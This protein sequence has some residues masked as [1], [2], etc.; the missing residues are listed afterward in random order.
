VNLV[1][2]LRCGGFVGR[3]RCGDLVRGSCRCFWGGFVV[4]GARVFVVFSA[5]GRFFA[6][7]ERREEV[8]CVESSD[9]NWC[10]G[11]GIIAV[12]RREDSGADATLVFIIVLLQIFD[13]YLKF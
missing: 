10:L 13:C 7:F 1:K 4:A 11:A 12:I 5:T 6:E 2:G 9:A 8:V 3:L